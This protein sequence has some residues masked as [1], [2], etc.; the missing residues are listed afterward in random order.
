MSQQKN[1]SL[2]I[3]I[4]GIILFGIIFKLAPIYYYHQGRSFIKKE[5]YT[6]AR[7]C[8]KNAYFFDQNNKDIR[9]YYVQSLTK[10]KPTIDVQKEV[11]AIA[12][13]MLEDSAQLVAQNQ[14][15]FWRDNV[16]Y[17]IGENYIEQAPYD[18]GIIRWDKNKFPLRISIANNSSKSLPQYYNSEIMKAFSQWQ[19]SV[20]FLK[21]AVVDNSDEANIEI[22]IV[23]L[24]A[25]VCSEDVCKYVV[26]YTN[27]I[28]KGNILKKMIIT[29]YAT[30]PKGNF[31]SDKEL[32]NT[33]LHEIGHALGIMGHSYSCED[34]MYMATDNGSYYAPYR[35]SFQYISTKD[36]NTLKLLYKMLP[37]ITNTPQEQINTKGLIYSP[38][39]LG[40]NEQISNRKL[41]EAQ[42]Y[43][44][45][46]PEVSG[47]YV[48][49]AVAYAELNHTNKAIKALNKALEL[50]KSNDEKFIALYNLAAINMNINNLDEAQK[51]AN[52]AKD[53]HDCPEIKE[54]LININ[55]AIKSKTKPFKHNLLNEA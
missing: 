51:Y 54:L 3:F 53:I 33:I 2:K 22:R 37:E 18:K 30:D 25:D 14:I 27:P 48:D 28:I 16:T 41:K 12:N 4:F 21:F 36:I 40:T 15:D 32:Y 26:G 42:N 50:S 49:L 45:K 34:L 13:G 31:F 39:I 44:R 8:L 17:N 5:N 19:A 1:N 46:A 6:K 7:N 38:I 47:G 35:S 43:I 10:L 55:H 20:E 24:P 29:L 9:Y 23:P 11:F 52:Q